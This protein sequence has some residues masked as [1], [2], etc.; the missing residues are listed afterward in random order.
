MIEFIVLVIFVFIV[1]FFVS[2]YSYQ[3]GYKNGLGFKTVSINSLP[4]RAAVKWLLTHEKE[5][6]IIDVMKINEDLLKLN[7]VNL[8]KDIEALAGKIHFEV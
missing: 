8:P 6:H 7:D 1:I 4:F 5:R 3:N 2:F